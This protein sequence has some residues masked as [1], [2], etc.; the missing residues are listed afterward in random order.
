MSQPHQAPQAPQAPECF[1][2]HKA[3]G[4][5]NMPGPIAL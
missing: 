1:L 2:T 4:Q 5:W 3:S